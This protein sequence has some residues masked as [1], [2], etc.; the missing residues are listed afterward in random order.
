M[1]GDQSR[2]DFD[3]GMNTPDTTISVLKEIKEKI[4]YR[5]NRN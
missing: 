3:V 1:N 5:K 4:L 2:S